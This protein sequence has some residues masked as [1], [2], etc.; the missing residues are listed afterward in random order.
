M[1]LKHKYVN[2]TSTRIWNIGLTCSF[3]LLLKKHFT[4]FG[5]VSSVR[6]RC[7]TLY[8]NARDLK[9]IS[10]INT[11]FK[12]AYYTNLMVPA[13]MMVEEFYNIKKWVEINRM[14]LKTAK[15]KET[16][17]RRSNQHVDLLPPFATP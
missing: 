11:M 8:N 13:I 14:H 15:A 1:T 9:S 7:N 5:F 12:Y 4:R 3:T 6:L 17:V 10:S 16:T 2:L